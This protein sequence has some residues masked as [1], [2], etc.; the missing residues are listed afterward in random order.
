MSTLFILISRNFDLH[1][2]SR[3]VF[4]PYFRKAAASL[5][6]LV[7]SKSAPKY[8]WITLLIDA[9]P[10]LADNVT[11]TIQE[12]AGVFF[13]SEQ[14]YELMQCL[15]ELQNDSELPVKQVCVLKRMP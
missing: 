5:H 10:F 8:F 14:T 6:S 15:H 1:L 9:L 7:W 2:I 4:L 3:I 13:S 12:S 11:Q